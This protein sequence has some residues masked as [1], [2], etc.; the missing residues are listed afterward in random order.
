[1]EPRKII[2]GY[3]PFNGKG[4]EIDDI[5]LSYCTPENLKATIASIH[6]PEGKYTD[7]H[8]MK[9]T[10]VTALKESYKNLETPSY[11]LKGQIKRMLHD[12]SLIDSQGEDRKAEESIQ[13]AVITY[14]TFDKKDADFF[15]TDLYSRTN[16]N[17]LRLSGYLLSAGASYQF[18]DLGEDI[19]R[20][21]SVDRLGDLIATGI[22]YSVTN[23]NADY[24][25][26]VSYFFWGCCE[27]PRRPPPV[28]S[29]MLVASFENDPRKVKLVADGYPQYVDSTA[30][31]LNS[32]YD[33]LNMGDSCNCQCCL[34]GSLTCGFYT[35][36]AYKSETIPTNPS[37]RQPYTLVDVVTAKYKLMSAASTWRYDSRDKEQI[38]TYFKSKIDPI[39]SIEQ[40]LGL[41]EQFLENKV[42]ND[43]ELPSKLFMRGLFG[44]T[45][46][47][48]LKKEVIQLL[49]HR[50]LHLLD[51][52]KADTL[53]MPLLK[54]FREVSAHDLFNENHITRGVSRDGLV[55][56]LQNITDLQDYFKMNDVEMT[57]RTPLLGKRS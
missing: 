54:Q 56:L 44:S 12:F 50:V 6:V 39:N 52:R 28:W 45:Q 7:L 55:K 15:L 25:S 3:V 40:C 31:T 17:A 1:M 22:D 38:R 19:I 24:L 41:Y 42:Y 30:A 11:E 27:F 5:V 23:R 33:H 32:F 53:P 43:V 49:Q 48:P 47:L 20:D 4:R 29:S 51:E 14:V 26:K 16:I 57:I 37:T 2:E 35:P 8:A 18:K 34:V 10:Y 36:V 46:Y 13:S 21:L 9:A